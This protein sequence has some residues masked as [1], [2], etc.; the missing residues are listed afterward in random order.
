MGLGEGLTLKNQCQS[1]ISL[2]PAALCYVAA[3]ISGPLS[4]FINGC[5][6]VGYFPDFLKLARV[7]PV[8][9]KGDPTQLGH[10]RPISVLPVISKIFERVI[11]GRLLKFLKKQNSILPGQY[12]FR[13]GH[14]TYMAILDMV[15][16]VRKA[17]E[18]GEHCL[19]VF[20]DFKKAFDTVDH[21][22]LLAKMEHLGIR[23]IPLELMRSYLSNR[24]QYVVFGSSESAHRGVLVGVPQGSILGPFL[25]YI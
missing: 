14:S 4:V 16:K 11:Q 17:W 25:C 8:F 3:E 12:G 15:E 6:E 24:M 9:K 22:I 2:S 10:Y 5:L 21:S 7:T 18:E 13:R 23:G 19:G 20:V 1:G